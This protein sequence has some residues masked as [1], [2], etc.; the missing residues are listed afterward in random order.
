[1][2]DVGFAGQ[3]DLPIVRF[4]GEI[5]G[6]NDLGDLIGVKI[7]RQNLTQSSYQFFLR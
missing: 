4:M 7:R 5:V 6:S 1:M 3:S 2:A